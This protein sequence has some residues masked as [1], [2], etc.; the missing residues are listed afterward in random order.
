MNNFAA[1]LFDYGNTIIQFDRPQ[2]GEIIARL[3]RQLSEEIA[4]VTASVLRTATMEAHALPHVGDPPSFRE[5]DPVD[6]ME[7]VLR[8]SYGTALEVT[9]EHAVLANERLQQYFVESIAIPPGAVE[10][11]EVLRRRAAVGLVSNYPCG[12]AL[13]RSLDDVG[14]RELLDPVIVSGDVDVGYV[15]PHAKPFAVAL[16]RLDVDPSRVLFVG[17]R[18]EMDMLGARDVGMR[19]CHITG[20][21]SDGEWGARYSTYRPDFVI[22]R[23]EDL[24]E[25]AGG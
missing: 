4:P 7:F 16:A 11:L 19:T 22:E 13:R 12:D 18:W 6:Q 2:I 3:A 5:S 21:T 23:L 10:V 14:V 17:D 24:L 9:R 15:K 8:R 1:F 20:L 25:I